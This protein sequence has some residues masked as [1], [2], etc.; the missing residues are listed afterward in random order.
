MITKRQANPPSFSCFFVFG[1]AAVRSRAYALLDA[2]KREQESASLKRIG[3]SFK[4]IIVVKDTVNTTRDEDGIVTMNLF[5]FL[6]DPDS[7]DR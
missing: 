4:K 2:A 1:I 7:L 3:D 6:L 5:N